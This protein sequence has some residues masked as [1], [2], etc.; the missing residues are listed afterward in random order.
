MRNRPPAPLD[1]YAAVQPLLRHVRIM[2]RVMAF[3]DRNPQMRTFHAELHREY[4]DILQKEFAPHALML[5]LAITE[6]EDAFP[7]IAA[8]VE[9]G[10]GD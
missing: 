4:M 1:E 7:E 3:V 5:A 2:E 10:P 8:L 9:I 6:L